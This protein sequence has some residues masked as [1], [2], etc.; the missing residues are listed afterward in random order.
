MIWWYI[1]T[2]VLNIVITVH[3]SAN[4][5]I[6]KLQVKQAVAV[7]PP[8]PPRQGDQFPGNDVPGHATRQKAQASLPGGGS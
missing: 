6:A 7:S 4:K 2:L 1:V 8:I 3:G 5:R